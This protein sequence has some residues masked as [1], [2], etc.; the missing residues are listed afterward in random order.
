[1]GVDVPVSRERI[2]HRSGTVAHQTLVVP[3]GEPI[4]F[5]ITLRDVIHSSWS[6]EIGLKRDAIPGAGE[7]VLL[8]STRCNKN[9][10]TTDVRDLSVSCSL[11][12]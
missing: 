5:K 8:N 9:V 3:I 12:P 4:R 10:S 6:P 1:M 11:N 7:T 2:T